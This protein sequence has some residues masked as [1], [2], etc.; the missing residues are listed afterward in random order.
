MLLYLVIPTLV[1]GWFGRANAK[2]CL[3]LTV[4][5]LPLPLWDFVSPKPGL[6]IRQLWIAGG[7]GLWEILIAVAFLKWKNRGTFYAAVILTIL[8]LGVTKFLP[9]FTPEGMFGFLG[10]SYVTFR[11]LDVVFSINDK[12]ITKLN[13]GQLLGFLFFFPT[14]SSGPIDRYRRFGQDWNRIRG[15]HEFIEDFD[16]A[17]QRV[18]QGFLYKFIIAALLRTYWVDPAAKHLGFWASA[19]YMYAYTFY[20][21]FDFAGYS[22]FAIGFSRLFGIRTPE[23]FDKPFLSKNIRDFWNRWHISLSFWFRDHIYMRF[24]L[25]AGKKKWF[26]G[27]HTASYIGLFL[28]FGIMGV[29]HGPER[30]YILYGLYHA[31]LLCCYDAFA[32]WNK[33]KKFWKDG[34]LERVV[35]VLLTFHFFAFGLLIFSGRFSPP[36][37]PRHEEMAERWDC[38]HLDGWVWDATKPNEPLAVDVSVDDVYVGRVMA[39]EPRDDMRSRGYSNVAHGFTFKLPDY[40]RDGKEHTIDAH[41]VD[42]Q[43]TRQLRN[44]PQVIA[45]EMDSS[46]VAPVPK[47]AEPP[48]PPRASAAATPAP[49]VPSVPPAPPT[50]SATPVPTATPAPATP[51]PATPAP[52][53]AGQP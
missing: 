7:Y 37:V 29:W 17:V 25:T 13:F 46:A 44:C 33:Q 30:H 6:E 2:W 47:P 26:K 8:P 14:L 41:V 12:V 36:Q 10:I 19:N 49:A 1:M 20:L 16:A 5:L 39:N 28:T 31:T 53:P 22:A 9:L 48:A 45:C 21:F 18:F 3:L 27:K 38:R 52:P 34:P 42:G 15:R 11:A 35:D 50:L 23:N 24:L 43:I 32:R 40:I 51:P 4:L